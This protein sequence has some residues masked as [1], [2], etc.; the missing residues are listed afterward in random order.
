MFRQQEVNTH[1]N[2]ETKFH[3]PAD[4]SLDESWHDRKHSLTLTKDAVCQKKIATGQKYY[5]SSNNVPS[6]DYGCKAAVD[7][8]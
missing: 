1:S 2:N 7:I 4:S 6:N 8:E 5:F 3:E